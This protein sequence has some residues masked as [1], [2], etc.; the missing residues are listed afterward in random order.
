VTMVDG[1]AKYLF[2]CQQRKRTTTRSKKCRQR[3][4]EHENEQ[5]RFFNTTNSSLHFVV[6][7]TPLTG[8]IHLIMG[9]GNCDDCL[10]IEGLV[11]AIDIY[12]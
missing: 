5:V 11:K 4:R 12:R 2:E 6:S 10:D 1:E 7:M 9:H 8:P 3:E